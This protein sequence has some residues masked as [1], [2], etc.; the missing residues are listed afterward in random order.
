MLFQYC[1]AISATEFRW[2]RAEIGGKNA[3]FEIQDG[4]TL[5]KLVQY[6]HADQFTIS[7]GGLFQ[8]IVYYAIPITEQEFNRV[9]KQAMG[10]LLRT[11]K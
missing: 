9:L 10:R 1:L 11:S 3:F 8:N 6:D 5:W 7:V 4:G 2:Y